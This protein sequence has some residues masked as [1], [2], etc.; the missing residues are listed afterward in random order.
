[1]ARARYESSDESSDDE[2]PAL[3]DILNRRRNAK[4]I[5]HQSLPSHG[6]MTEP[7]SPGA[8]TAGHAARAVSF[9]SVARKLP[10]PAVP[11]LVQ[12]ANSTP[13]APKRQRVLKPASMDNRLARPVT[14][15]TIGSIASLDENGE[16]FRRRS[17]IAKRTPARAAKK[18]SQYL[19]GESSD[20]SSMVQADSA[21]SSDS[22]SEFE[23]DEGIEGDPRSA[24]HSH[25]SDLSAE[26]INEEAARQPHSLSTN[27]QESKLSSAP[28]LNDMS[29]DG[30]ASGF[31]IPA[32]EITSIGASTAPPVLRKPESSSIGLERPPSSSSADLNAILT[33]SPPRR[34]SPHKKPKFASPSD[35]Q[36]YQMPPQKKSPAKKDTTRRSFEQRKHQL[37]QDFLE[38]LDMTIT[39]GQI[40]LLTAESGGVKLVWSKTL[41]T[42][43][44]RANWK[45]ESMKVR[46]NGMFSAHHKHH[47]SIELAEKVID[48]EDRL[49]NVIAHEFCHLTNFMISNVR[50]N[51][52]GKEF[53]GW[54][55]AWWMPL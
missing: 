4:P 48:D 50:D 49:I 18:T 13:V 19:V 1:M 2:L 33:Y 5:G 38:E 15:E 44:G 29:Q 36:S 54:Y 35:E 53:K 39:K 55:E 12:K 52:H 40:S 3:S 9:T 7:S 41:S 42:T 30:L 22:E 34:I 25:F 14:A 28:L 51:P 6:H 27:T 11:S 21:C 45:K 43:A 8:E 24:S 17:P 32:Y 23:P 10:E 37:A 46:E 26:D 16:S 20:A 47:A 31:S